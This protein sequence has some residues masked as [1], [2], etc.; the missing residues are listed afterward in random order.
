MNKNNVI[1]IIS[2]SKGHYPI[3]LG[4]I[5]NR[6]AVSIYLHAVAVN[7]KS[8]PCW[9][10]VSDGFLSLK[11]KEIVFTL[12]SQEGEDTA[13]FPTQPLQLFLL[14]YKYATQ[15]PIN[16]GEVIKLGEKGLFGFPA[17]ACTFPLVEIPNAPFSRPTLS[18][19][20]LTKDEFLTA[21]TYGLTRVISRLG[22]EQKRYPCLAANVRGRKSIN[23]QPMIQKSQLKN[24][25][26]TSIKQGSVYM[27]G[28]DQVVLNFPAS[29]RVGLANGLK[30]HPAN[31]SLCLLMQLQPKHEGCLVWF[32]ENDSTEMHMKPNASGESI[33]GS[34][35]LLEPGQTKDGA[36]IYEDGFVM[37]FTPENWQQFI[38]AVAAGQF[39]QINGTE[40][41][42]EFILTWGDQPLFTGQE[43]SNEQAS[44]G[45]LF[46][47]LLKKF[48][49]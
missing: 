39:L 33:A 29:V 1:K 14:L 24:I 6:L 30:K 16:A 9:S 23:W 2:G 48:K 31:K 26:R 18:T 45:N 19:I 5:P 21:H 3:K 44:S 43:S 25:P 4:I 27:F 32:A 38:G 36:S 15:K 7:G 37:D 11:Q 47:K 42:M 28:G 41:G 22:F 35:I 13:K 17:L 40:G 8:I 10:Y 46:K 20:L 49:K 12:Q 34:F